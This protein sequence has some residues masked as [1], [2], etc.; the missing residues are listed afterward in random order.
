MQV[1]GD[2][3]CGALS[4]AENGDTLL[5]IVN[6]D[7]TISTLCRKK[8]DGSSG[9][10]VELGISTISYSGGSYIWSINLS[11]QGIPVQYAIGGARIADFTDPLDPHWTQ[12]SGTPR[13]FSAI[14]GTIAQFLT[15]LDFADPLGSLTLLDVDVVLE[16][17]P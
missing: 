4:P 1:P 9:T 8:D 16:V 12:P 2:D 5:L 14:L 13:T 17:L 15:P 11:L 3:V 10:T 6:N 7:L